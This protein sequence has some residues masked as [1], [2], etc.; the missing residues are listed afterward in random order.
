M[1]W[2]YELNTTFLWD[3]VADTYSTPAQPDWNTFCAGQSLMADGR[4]FV[5]GGHVAVSPVKGDGQGDVA[6]D[7]GIY[8]PLDNT[9]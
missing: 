4:L 1:V 2:N 6:P 9:Y 3:P 5:A 7:A 8:N